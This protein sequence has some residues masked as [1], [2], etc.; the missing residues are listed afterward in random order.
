MTSQPLNG[1]VARNFVRLGAVLFLLGL[2]T[3]LVSNF[4]AN[5]RMGLSAHLEGVMNGAF[6]IA[7]GAAWGHVRLT[8][9]SE[10]AAFLLLAYGTSV[11]WLT[12]IL[13][14]VWNTGA[15]TPIASTTPSAAAWQEGVVT[16]GLISISLAMIAGMAIVIRGLFDGR[17]QN[18]L[19]E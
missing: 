14:A 3:G 19:S 8:A 9:G 4:A 12:I 1:S 2:L 5:P 17:N 15:L 10:K 16:A 6:L 11:N 7:L 18:G 13:A